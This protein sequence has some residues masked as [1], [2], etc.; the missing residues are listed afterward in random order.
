MSGKNRV[1]KIFNDALKGDTIMDQKEKVIVFGASKMGEAAY[2]LLKE[3]YEIIYFCDNA[4]NKW[5]KDF[6]GIEIIS[7]QSLEKDGLKN[8]QVI[9]TSMYY[10]E[11]GKQLENMGIKNYQV[12]NFKFKSKEEVRYCDDRYK[13]FK[14]MIDDFYSNNEKH[15]KNL[16]LMYDNFYNKRFI[17]FLNENFPQNEHKFIIIKPINYE[18][19]YIDNI[20]KYD[21]VE[22]LYLEYFEAKLY[23]YVKNSKKVFIHYLYDHIC[24]FICK[25]DIGKDVELNWIV[26]GGD[27]YSYINYK[28]YDNSTQVLIN[29]NKSLNVLSKCTNERKSVIGKIN[30]FLTVCIGDYE[31]LTKKFIIDGIRKDFIYPNPVEYDV[32][33]N[34]ICKSEEETFFKYQNY[35]ENVILLGN[36][37]DPS[38]NHLEILHRLEKFKDEDFC[39]IC[40][41]SYGDNEYI[42]KI[43]NIGKN[44]F[45]NKF[46][47]LKKYL[48]SKEY[49][50]L[51]NEVDIVLM[52]H[53]RQQ[54]SGT[55]LAALYLGKKVFMR[56]ESNSKKDFINLGLNLYDTEEIFNINRVENLI[57]FKE[58][59][60]LSNKKVI[61]DYFDVKNCKRMYKELF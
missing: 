42:S 40:P 3:K 16:H 51:L 20:N 32:L 49:A 52:N 60:K 8:I 5:G 25:Y 34:I 56:N 61:E 28:L 48:S 11:I 12:F 46:I 30:N 35:F 31:L 53:R 23:Y 21:N 37:G 7:P 26:W 44:L 9:I 10:N 24:E 14:Y 43:I 17:E 57:G 58:K 36:S 45:G 13:E 2:I 29:N 19:K 6:C 55:V 33:K 59:Y 54:G 1:W 4:K 50:L 22:I 39:I 38:N 18:L 15:I 27:L 47:P 41:L